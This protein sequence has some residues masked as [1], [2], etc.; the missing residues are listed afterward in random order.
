MLNTS[1]TL[2]VKFY[3]SITKKEPVRDWLLELDP[4]DCKI[5]GIDIK[6]I[7]YF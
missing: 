6:V 7:E 5:I 2:T 3:R 4:K 1:K